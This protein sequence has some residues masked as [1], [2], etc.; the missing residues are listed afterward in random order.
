MDF[1]PCRCGDSENDRRKN[2][3]VWFFVSLSTLLPTAGVAF[4]SKSSFLLIWTPLELDSPFPEILVV[5]IL[6]RWK[7]EETIETRQLEKSDE[8]Y[9]FKNLG[10]KPFI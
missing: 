2:D 4:L 1:S 10:E 6:G 9:A 5:V 7:G 3:F 8:P